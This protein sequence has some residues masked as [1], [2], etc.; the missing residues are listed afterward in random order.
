MP[1]TNKHATA[2]RTSLD[3]E[4]YLSRQIDKMLARLE[5]NPRAR[6]EDVL[7]EEDIRLAHLLMRAAVNYVSGYTARQRRQRCRLPKCFNLY[8][9]RYR[10]KHSNLG[11]VFIVT[12]RGVDV[13]GSGFFEI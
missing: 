11:R 8:G 10:I 13:L 7:D 6:Y 2:K 9:R 3:E 12:R 4:G 1:K 5:A